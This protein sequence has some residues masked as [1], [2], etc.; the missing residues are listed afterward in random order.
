MLEAP[1]I[2]RCSAIGCCAHCSIFSLGGS[3]FQDRE[4]GFL[5]CFETPELAGEVT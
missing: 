2:E 3:D 5:Q 4:S 1:V